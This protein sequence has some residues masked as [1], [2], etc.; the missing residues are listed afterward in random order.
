MRLRV[1]STDSY[2]M[3]DPNIICLILWHYI[4]LTEFKCTMPYPEKIILCTHN[5]KWDS[6]N[7]QSLKFKYKL[8]NNISF[9]WKKQLILR[10]IHGNFRD[11]FHWKT[12]NR[13]EPILWKFS[14]HISQ[15]SDQF[16]TDL[17]NAFNYKKMAI[18]QFLSENDC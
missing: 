10:E 8:L 13:K 7:S 5:L 11:K 15:E 12:I 1:I 9:L 16:C 3:Q 18:C 2:H 14:E 17:T 6:E 4:E